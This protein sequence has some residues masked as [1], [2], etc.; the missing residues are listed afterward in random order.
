MWG[1]QGVGQSNVCVIMKTILL[2]FSDQIHVHQCDS[3]HFLS[4][5][6][7]I[8]RACSH[9]RNRL[10]SFH[11][12]VQTNGRIALKSKTMTS[13][14]GI[15]WRHYREFS[16]NHPVT[17][18]VNARSCDSKNRTEVY[19][20]EAICINSRVRIK[21]WKRLNHI[22]IWFVPESLRNILEVNLVWTKVFAIN[23]KPIQIGFVHW[24]ENGISEYSFKQY[25]W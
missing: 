2:L 24:C 1:G 10:D 16:G 3:H 12:C 4:R 25:R 5:S 19:R 21:S 17:G 13:P 14:K 11:T 23:S 9:R 18:H 15:L 20:I 7:F 6:C 22:A 8:L